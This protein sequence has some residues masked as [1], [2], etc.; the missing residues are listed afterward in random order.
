MKRSFRHFI[1][2]ALE[3]CDK[4]QRFTENMSYEEFAVDEKTF[5]AVTRALEVIGEAIKNIPED[6]KNQYKEIPWK[7]IIGFRNTVAHAY[8]G[9]DSK[10]VFNSAKEDTKYLKLILEEILKNLDE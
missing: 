8:F 7:E 6:I 3:Y 10:I 9:I 4:A 1:E 5:M 2:D